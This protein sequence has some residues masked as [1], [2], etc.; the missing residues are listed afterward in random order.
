MG[1]SSPTTTSSP[2]SIAFQS[3][4]IMVK[5]HK[6]LLSSGE[7]EVRAEWNTGKP[8]VLL[9]YIDNQ[10]ELRNVTDMTDISV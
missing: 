9:I 3:M 1:P 7:V 10:A 8:Q 6:L 4:K 5:V 2:A